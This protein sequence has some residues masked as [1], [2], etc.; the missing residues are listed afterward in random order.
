MNKKLLTLVV[1]LI[2]LLIIITTMGIFAFL[3]KNKAK[4]IETKIFSGVIFPEDYSISFLKEGKRYT[5]SS[6]DI[7]KAEEILEKCLKEQNLSVY[8]K[9]SQY[10]RQYFGLINADNGKIIYINAGI[11]FEEFEKPN[12]K[13][14]YVSVN[15]G[16]DNF[17][18]IK[19][20]LNQEKCFDFY[21]NGV[22]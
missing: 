1:V 21:V 13:K 7:T 5:P 3:N 10:K 15:D 8:S 2:I 11:G 14:D 22:A 6:E 18:N 17:F 9:L 20:N 12:W 19:V 16:G 4:V